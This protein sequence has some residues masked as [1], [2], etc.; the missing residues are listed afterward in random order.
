MLDIGSTD[1]VPFMF[2]KEI[3]KQIHCAW[4]KDKW[5]SD[6]SK[7]VEGEGSMTVFPGK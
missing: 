4:Y 6:S 5:F 1:M 3:C 2:S 7:E